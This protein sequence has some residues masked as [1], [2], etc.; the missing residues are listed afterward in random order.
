MSL[1]RQFGDDI[2]DL[3]ERVRRST[4]EVRNGVEG[5][6]AGTVCHSRGLVLTNAHVVGR[7]QPTVVLHDGQV[8]GARVL[9]C[10]RA[11]DLAALALEREDLLPI[12]LGDSSLLEPGQFVIAIGHPWGVKSAATAGIVMQADGRRVQVRYPGRMV[13]VNLPLRPGNSGGPLV[14]SEG[15]L[16][17][18][19]TAMTGPD[20]GFAIPVD[21]AKS[22]LRDSVTSVNTL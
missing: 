10:D 15:R 22:F 14:D 12:A 2:A 5:G 1:M 16:V 7:S 20:T 17:G 8:V 4:V 3:A 9:A 19:N 18:I 13:A 21:V 11:R 6:A